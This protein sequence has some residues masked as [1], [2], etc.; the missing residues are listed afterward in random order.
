MYMEKGIN[1]QITQLVIEKEQTTRQYNQL[2]C[3][4]QQKKQLKIGQLTYRINQGQ[5]ENE[6]ERERERENLMKEEKKSE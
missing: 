2:A 4:Q 3:I 6:G 5:N 1:D